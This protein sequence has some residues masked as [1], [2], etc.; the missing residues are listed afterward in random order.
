MNKTKKSSLYLPTTALLLTLCSWEAEHSLQANVLQSTSASITN[1]SISDIAI[2]NSVDQRSQLT[3]NKPAE[4]QE[5][6]PDLLPDFA[7]KPVQQRKSEFIEFVLPHIEQENVRIDSIRER[8]VSLKEDSD[9]T[10]G[11]TDW[12]RQ[13]S[14]KYRL[15]GAII[16][17]SLIEELL[18]RVDQLPPSLVL[19]QAAIESAWGTSRFA[20]KANN[21]F[22]HWC[23]TP[24]C[25]LVPRERP[26]N[27]SYEV[28]KF[29]NVG[30]AVHR[31]FMNLNT[32]LAY[33][34]MREIRTC[35]REGGE[36]LSGSIMAGG[37]LAYSGRGSAYIESL[38]N[39]IRINDWE[40]MDGISETVAYSE[41]YVSSDV[42]V[43]DVAIGDE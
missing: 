41:C 17:E 12:L 8:L 20:R 7:A 32:N 24:G 31:Y 13:I 33:E 22:G 5:E 34:E 25:G 4:A 43:A 40:R 27:A 21:I 37:L 23:M 28:H 42:A 39:L 11:D 15:Y 36:P 18:T 16:D 38:R 26:E 30:Q 35:H 1:T 19:A 2:V 29:D 6:L 3:L 9:W 10:E 14:Q